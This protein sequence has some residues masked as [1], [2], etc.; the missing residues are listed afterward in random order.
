MNTPC[1][2]GVRHWLLQPDKASPTIRVVALCNNDK[3]MTMHLHM[4][5][6][7]CK[8]IMDRN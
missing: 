2:L 4:M 7:V 8:F 1:K 6:T 3:T 5:I